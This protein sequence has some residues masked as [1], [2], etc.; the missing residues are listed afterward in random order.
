[1]AE[2][3]YSLAAILASVFVLAVVTDKFFIPSLD[4]I[5]RRLKLSD[6]VAGASLMAIG[7]SA[8]ELA[9]A[10]MALF[11][12]GGAHSDVGIGTIVGSAV[13]NILVITGVS[14]VVAG[15][16]HIH[17]FAV[18][19]DIVYYLISILYLG[20]VFF[21]GRVSLIEA[22]L[23]LVGYAVYMGVLILLKDPEPDEDAQAGAKSQISEPEKAKVAGWR[24]LEALIETSLRRV[25][26]AP[27]AN[28]VW[29]FAVS[30][31]LIVALS[32]ALVESTIVFAAGIGIPPV[33]VA[34]TLLAAGTSAPD[35][36]ASLEVAR[37]GR[38]GMAVAQ[39]GRLQHLRPAGGLGAALDDCPVHSGLERDR[40]RRGRPVDA[41]RHPGGD[42][43]DPGALSDQQTRAEPAGRLDLAAALRPL[44][45]LHACQRRCGLRRSGMNESLREP[46]HQPTVGL[47]LLRLPLIGP[48]LRA[49]HGRLLLQAPFTLVALALVIDGFAGPQTAARNLAT[50]APWVHLRGIVVLALLLAGNLICMGCP[51]TLPRTLAKRLSI[52]GRRFS[53]AAAQ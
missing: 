22:L 44:R 36:M 53:P 31:V 43:A 34:L 52:K 33:I 11:N 7:S 27:K 21:D 10:L 6:E 38:G 15:G 40:R 39:R 24:H 30:I 14:A 41:D 17:I 37:E 19:R 25:T 26:G 46:R 29:A 4:E 32:Y 51:F 2:V 9:I 12:D 18:G 35:L 28:F 23:G 16:L 48:L 8:P 5:S 3:S 20:L 49:R 42:D 50:V 1:M 45:R 13:F 47:D